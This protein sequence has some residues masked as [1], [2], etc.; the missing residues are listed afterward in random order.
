MLPEVFIPTFPELL[1]LNWALTWK[2]VST[3]KQRINNFFIFSVVSVVNDIKYTSPFIGLCRWKEK[4][5]SLEID[6]TVEVDVA[7]DEAEFEGAGE[8]WRQNDSGSA[9]GYCSLIDDFA[10][11]IKELERAACA[12]CGE[13]QLITVL[14]DERNLDGGF[15]MRIMRASWIPVANIHL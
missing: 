6:V 11:G 8:G 3:D 5:M 1:T 15:G 9:W 7:V 2:E 12:G 13:S 10:V 4:K 14:I